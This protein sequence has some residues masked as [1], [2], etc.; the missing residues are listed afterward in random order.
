MGMTLNDFEAKALQV[1]LSQRFL[2]LR[3]FEEEELNEYH[4]ADIQGEMNLEDFIRQYAEV[5]TEQFEAEY[6]NRLKADM[7]AILIELRQ[8]IIAESWHIESFDINAN[9][10]VVQISDVDKVIQQKID[11]LKEGADV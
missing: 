9:D 5:I 4:I 8:D 2:N 6:E 1:L 11:K 7:V 3:L 10:L